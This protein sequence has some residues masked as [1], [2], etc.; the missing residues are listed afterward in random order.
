M[1]SPYREIPLFPESSEF[2][3]VS[4]AF[5]RDNANFHL[6]YD[7]AAFNSSADIFSDSIFF[8]I[9]AIIRS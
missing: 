1:I 3:S 2:L 6:T 9:D 5:R 7:R 4:T 8:L